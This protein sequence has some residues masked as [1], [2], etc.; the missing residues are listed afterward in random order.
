MFLVHCYFIRRAWIICGQSKPFTTLVSVLALVHLAFGLGSFS[1]VSSLGTWS[2]V[3]Q[4]P[5]SLAFVAGG[6]GC[7]ALMDALI[8]IGLSLG[9]WRERDTSYRQLTSA[10]DHL[11]LYFVATGALTALTS[12]GT[13]VAYAAHGDGVLL[14]FVTIQS[15]VY[16][17]SFVTN[18]NSRRVARAR[19]STR[20]TSQ[21]AS[22]SVMLSSVFPHEIQ[23]WSTKGDTTPDLIRGGIHTVRI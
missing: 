19:L 15:K 22:P 3:K 13:I 16:A 11:V 2:R 23:P 20:G 21:D 7:S 17:N 10:I 4:H 14:G 5:A 1:L 9:L 18:L 12:V 6:L 8:A